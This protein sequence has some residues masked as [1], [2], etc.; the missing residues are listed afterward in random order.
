MSFSATD[1]NT[2]F[3]DMYLL[4]YIPFYC[5]NILTTVSCICENVANNSAIGVFMS[6]I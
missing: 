5:R 3:I 6:L 4:P 1:Y 2:V